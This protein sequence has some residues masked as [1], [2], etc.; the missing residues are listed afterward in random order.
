MISIPASFKK[1]PSIPISPNSFS[2]RTVLLPSR[3]SFNSF[4][5]RVVLPAPR[6]RILHLFS[7]LFFLQSESK[8]HP[9]YFLSYFTVLS[10]KRLLNFYQ[11]SHNVR[12]TLCGCS[13]TQLCYGLRLDHAVRHHGHFSLFITATQDSYEHTVSV[14]APPP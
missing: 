10:I 5:I 13:H 4:L 11:L 7:S 2:I 9:F 14:K 12:Q 8:T 3:A 1:P 6:N